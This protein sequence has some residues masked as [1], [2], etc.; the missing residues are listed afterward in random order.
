MRG[1]LAYRMVHIRVLRVVEFI[2]INLSNSLKN[3]L[4]RLFIIHKWELFNI[5]ILHIF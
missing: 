4:E 5:Y 2:Y 3:T 1:F